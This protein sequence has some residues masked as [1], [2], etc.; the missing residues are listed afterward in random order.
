M[1]DQVPAPGI[2]RPSAH[3]TA[4][5][6]AWAGV[7][8]ELEYRLGLAAADAA[9]HSD[10][11]TVA[12]AA[13]DAPGPWTPPTGI[14]P[15]PAELVARA[16]ELLAGQRELGAE[17]EAGKNEIARHLAAIRSVPAMRAPSASVYLD[18]TG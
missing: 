14:G 18:V 2:T 5:A 1:P 3:P 6:I 16:Q 10:R 4:Q 15:I 8:D 9:T 17:L 7:L 11:D 13:I 12:G